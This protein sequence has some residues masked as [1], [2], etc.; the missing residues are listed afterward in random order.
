MLKVLME[1]CKCPRGVFGRLLAKTMNKGHA[2]LSRWAFSVCPPADGE[3]VLDIG[4]GGG[5]NLLRLLKSCPRSYVMGVDYSET[6]VACSLR[7]TSKWRNRCSVICA[8]VMNLPV[9]SGLFDRAVSFESVYFWPDP[10]IAL[11]EIARVLKP[12]GKVT[13]VTEMSDPQKGKFWTKRCPGMT[14]YTP[15]ELVSFLEKAGFSD[16]NVYRTHGVRSKERKNKGIRESMSVTEYNLGKYCGITFPGYP[17]EDVPGY[18]AEPSARTK[19]YGYWK[20]YARCTD[21]IFRR[22][23]AGDSLTEIF[24]IG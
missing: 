6:S 5:A 4:C 24:R 9:D 13:V 15:E 2:P 18:I 21:C 19:L 17:L 23:T 22:M 11:T 16:V 12:H 14:V 7:L 3:S 20:V 1:N 8:D 10:V